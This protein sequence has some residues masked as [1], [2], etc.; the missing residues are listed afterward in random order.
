[1]VGAVTRYNHEGLHVTG[2]E[3][4]LTGLEQTETN[5]IVN[6]QTCTFILIIIHVSCIYSSRI[7]VFCF[8]LIHK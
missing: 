1:M 2:A 7:M 6:S 3:L 5:Q 4:T 8:V